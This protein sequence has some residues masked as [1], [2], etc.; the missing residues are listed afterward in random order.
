MG[1]GAVFVTLAVLLFA[2]DGWSKNRLELGRPDGGAAALCGCGGGGGFIICLGT[3]RLASPDD[4]TTL[5]L[6]ATP[7]FKNRLFPAAPAAELC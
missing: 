1:G 4:A 7:G 6:P 5:I 3:P 2:E